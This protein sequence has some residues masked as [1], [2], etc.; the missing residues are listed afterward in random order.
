MSGRGGWKARN[1]PRLHWTADFS[2]RVP[3]SLPPIP[4][5]SP[6]RGEGRIFGNRIVS[7]TLD[8]SF[9]PLLGEPCWGVHYDRQL[10]LSMNFGEPSLE[11][12]EP[13]ETDSKS[14]LARRVASRRVVTVRGR[15]WLWVH[16]CHWRLTLR[17]VNQAT[18]SSSLR[19]IERVIK[20]LEGQKLTSVAVQPETGASRFEFD[21]G[22]VLHCRRLSRDSDADL[23][24]LY[25]P[26]GYVLSVAGD[27]TIGHQRG[28]GRSS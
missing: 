1:S 12:R 6:A 4:G 28:R 11:I 17:D 25:K 14:G 7:G 9:A 22:C 23:W 2:S 24:L 10:N 18:G 21:L 20:Q 16:C 19:R 3:R 27:G 8:K 26:N 5:P 15:W 13:Y